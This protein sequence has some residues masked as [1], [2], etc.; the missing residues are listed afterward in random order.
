MAAA[1]TGGVTAPTSMI[2]VIARAAAGPL[3]LRE[4]MKAPRVHYAGIPDKVF[5]EAEMPKERIEALKKKGHNVALTKSIGAVTAVYCPSG[6]PNTEG[7][8]CLSAADP[9]GHGI[10]LG[11][12]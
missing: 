1:G 5:V 11:G 2:N 10:A 12:N 7:I 9:R 3:S 8:L 4:A 6:V